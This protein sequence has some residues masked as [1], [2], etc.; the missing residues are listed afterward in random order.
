MQSLI[1]RANA[2][3]TGF[4]GWPDLEGF[5]QLEMFRSSLSTSIFS[6]AFLMKHLS[7]L[8]V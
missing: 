1:A 4:G 5:Y 6:N 8:M 3:T 7:H 2:G